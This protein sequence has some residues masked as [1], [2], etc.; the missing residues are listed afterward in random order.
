MDSPGIKTKDIL[1]II[2]IGGVIVGSLAFPSLPVALIATHKAFKKLNARDLGRIVKRLEKQEMISVS[3]NNGKTTIG[4]TEKGKK[5]LLEY[6]FER[7]KLKS[8]KRDGKFRLII[9]D[10]PETQR[11]ARDILRKKLEQL[12]FIRL[13]YSVY[14]SAFPCKDEID[15]LSHFLGISKYIT[16]AVVD[17]IERGHKLSFIKQ[18]TYGY[19]E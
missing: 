19:N 11:S 8:K 18:N 17:K 5:R 3:E 1:K 13:Q 4:I 12:G 6:D 9:F 2:G 14:V 10:V 15:F 16:I 7:I